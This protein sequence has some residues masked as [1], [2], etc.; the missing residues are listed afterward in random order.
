[1]WKDSITCY[2]WRNEF[3]SSF[4]WN[5]RIYSK[6]SKGFISVVYNF[7]TG[8]FHLIAR[9]VVKSL[10]ATVTYLYKA[11]GF[12]SRVFSIDKGNKYQTFTLRNIKIYFLLNLYNC[13]NHIYYI[14]L[15][16]LYP[17]L[18]YCN[19]IYVFNTRF[20]YIEITPNII[21]HYYLCVFHNSVR[22][23]IY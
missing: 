16:Q 13:D 3:S 1:M 18:K 4:I 20:F 17:P 11:I 2:I 21:F 12:I 5:P 6:L 23:C 19:I 8:A 10:C 14:R 7:F 9:A 22:I 15:S